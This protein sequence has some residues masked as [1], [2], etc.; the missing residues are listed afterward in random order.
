MKKKKKSV[1]K[2]QKNYDV[3]RKNLKYLQTA[4][5]IIFYI[6]KITMIHCVKGSKNI[7]YKYQLK[8]IDTLVIY[9]EQKRHLQLSSRE[10]FNLDKCSEAGAYTQSVKC[11]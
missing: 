2:M 6:Q 10:S 7:K 9:N 1:E 5:I 11:E 3:K 8:I 4:R